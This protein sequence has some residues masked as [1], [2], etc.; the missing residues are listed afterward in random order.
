MAVLVVEH[1][2]EAWEGLVVGEVHGQDVRRRDGLEVGPC[3]DGVGASVAHVDC[4]LA[5]EHD[6]VVVAEVV[7]T[8]IVAIATAEAA[9]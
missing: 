5:A 6:A 4:G 3:L 1:L 8:G 9:G 7:A 2:G